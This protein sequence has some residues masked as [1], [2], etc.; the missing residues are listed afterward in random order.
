M[1]IAYAELRVGVKGSRPIWQKV[2][3]HTETTRFTFRVT[4]KWS[5]L[6]YP[7][8]PIWLGSFDGYIW[9]LNFLPRRQKLTYPPTFW[10]EDNGYLYFPICFKKEY[11]SPCTYVS[12]FYIYT[13]DIARATSVLPKGLNLITHGAIPAFLRPKYHLRKQTCTHQKT[14]FS[15]PK[16]LL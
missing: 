14:I 15:T 10:K 8:T 16:S 12:T 2:V 9:E 3:Q 4:L 6:S 11:E 1:P 7:T 5:E 13:I